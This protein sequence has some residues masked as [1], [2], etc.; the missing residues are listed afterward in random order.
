M[1][2]KY[3]YLYLNKEKI[4]NGIEKF[5]VI[6]V[7]IINDDRFEAELKARRYAKDNK[8]GKLAGGCF[9]SSCLPCDFRDNYKVYCCP[10]NYKPAK[11]SKHDKFIADLIEAEENMEFTI[12]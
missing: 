5:E 1:K 12:F 6:R 8:L 11:E 10:A 3:D 9:D 2:T 7:K 4:V